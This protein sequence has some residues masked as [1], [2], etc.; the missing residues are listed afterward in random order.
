MIT[1]KEISILSDN[2]Q[3]C[4]ELEVAQNQRKFVSHNAKSLAEAYIKNKHEGGAKPY[5]IYNE[6]NTM[7][8]FVMYEYVDEKI[9]DDFGESA[10]YFWRLMID[11]KYQGKGYGKAAIAKILEEVRTKPLGEAKHM[12]ISYDPDND[13]VRKLYATYGFVETGTQ[14]GGE[15]LA[16]LVL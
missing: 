9:D 1:L 12:Y 7:V 4:I 16:K 15:D 3:A 11:E 14:I 6:E 5:A 10:Y 8:G 13:K 2:M